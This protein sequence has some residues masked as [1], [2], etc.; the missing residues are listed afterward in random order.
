MKRLTPFLFLLISAFIYPVFIQN[1][2]AGTIGTNTIDS[3]TITVPACSGYAGRVLI[4]YTVDGVNDRRL[5]TTA[6]ASSI[7]SNVGLSGAGS[8]DITH[9]FIPI[10]PPD[11]L[12]NGTIVTLTVRLTNIADTVL[13][14]T[15]VIQFVCDT[16]E[17]VVDTDGDGVYDKDDN[18]PTIP[19]IDQADSDNNGVGDACDTPIEPP[20]ETPE[21]VVGGV[22]MPQDYQFRFYWR[23][24][25]ANGAVVGYA[26]SGGLDVYCYSG[27][28]STLVMNITPTSTALSVDN[29]GCRMA[30]YVL[31]GGVYQLNVWSPDGKLYEI[32]ATN[33]R[34]DNARIRHT[35]PTR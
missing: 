25:N 16:G 34:F 14:D 24:S 18:C 17:I 30:F 28:V 5:E 27:G 6:P 9:Q 31:D 13:F 3:V 22:V 19:N 23:T 21:P 32:F 8:F 1:A 35:D 2:H 11:A 15:E 10:N 12:P 20:I 4:N 7:G 26:T 29:A 33:R